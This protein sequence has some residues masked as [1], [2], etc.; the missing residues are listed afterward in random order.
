MA[1]RIVGQ[2]FVKGMTIRIP[3]NVFICL[4]P[5]AKGKS[6]CCMHVHNP[7]SQCV[8][9]PPLTHRAVIIYSHGNATDCGGMLPRCIQMSEQLSVDV[10]LYDYEG[11]GYSAGYHT[12]EALYCDIDV[13]F[14]YALGCY[15]PEYI[16]LYGDSSGLPYSTLTSSWKRS[17]VLHGSQGGE[18][19]WFV[20]EDDGR[21]SEDE[22]LFKA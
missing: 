7:E 9:V 11:Y 5:V 19:W 1:N 18:S 2:L 8:L 17:Y 21:C 15:Y 10:I 20:T 4:L 16:F 12:E 13:V 22:L 14:Q 3:D 6:I